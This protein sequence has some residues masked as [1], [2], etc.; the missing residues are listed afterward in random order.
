MTIGWAAQPYEDDN[1][2]SLSTTAREAGEGVAADKVGE[3]LDEY[4]DGGHC[5]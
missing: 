4:V 1:N 2:V 5:G 3:T